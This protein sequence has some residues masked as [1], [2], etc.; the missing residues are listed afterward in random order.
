MLLGANYEDMALAGNR[1]AEIGGGYVL[2]CDGE[3]VAELGLPIAGL[4]SEAGIEEVASDLRSLEEALGDVLGADLGDKAL[5]NM[6]FL[7]L[8]NIPDYG[9][10]NKGL[11]ASDQRMQLVETVIEE[12]GTVT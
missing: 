11:V 3:I 10:T 5:I 2:A 12:G 6:N 4:M 8:P 1:L 7:S 9:F